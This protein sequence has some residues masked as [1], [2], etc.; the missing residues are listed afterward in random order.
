MRFC[1]L[2]FFKS[3]SFLDALSVWLSTIQSSPC[4]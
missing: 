2:N 1:V 4:P 3:F